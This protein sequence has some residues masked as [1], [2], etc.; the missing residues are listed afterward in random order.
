MDFDAR[1]L[2]QRRIGR[3]QDKRAHGVAAFLQRPDQMGSEE[4]AAPGDE[5]PHCRFLLAYWALSPSRWR[6]R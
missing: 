1:L 6:Q 2:E 4:P 3:R 5:N